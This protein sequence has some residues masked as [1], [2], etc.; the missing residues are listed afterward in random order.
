ML[1]YDIIN[2]L[3]NPYYMFVVDTDYGCGVITKSKPSNYLKDVLN[4][5]P[6]DLQTN[7]ND[8]IVNG[9]VKV[10]DKNITWDYFSENRK[11]LL[12]LIT[13]KQFLKLYD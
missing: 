1:R 4:K 2:Y 10:E 7:E 13:P 12:N 9:I 8:N 5:I 6:E 3:E 11:E